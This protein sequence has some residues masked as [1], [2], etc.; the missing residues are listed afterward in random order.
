MSFL[1]ETNA[2]A[3][4][5]EGSLNTFNNNNNNNHQQQFDQTSN[6]QLDAQN[7]DK[8]PFPTTTQP[9]VSIRSPLQALIAMVIPTSLQQLSVWTPFALLRHR[10][11]PIDNNT[12]IKTA[13]D[14]AA[15]QNPSKHMHN[16][17]NPMA[18][19][20]SIAAERSK[21]SI[22]K[23]RRLQ[24]SIDS[25]YHGGS[26]CKKTRENFT[27][28]SEIP[29]VQRDNKTSLPLE[30][31]SERQRQRTPDIF[32]ALKEKPRYQG[33]KKSI[34]QAWQR[35]D[36]HVDPHKH[37][38]ILLR[39]KG[40]IAR[41]LKKKAV[42]KVHTQRKPLS[43]VD[44][45]GVK[46]IP[47]RLDKCNS[48]AY[49]K[50]M[51]ESVKTNYSE[52]E[53]EV[54]R[55]RQWKRICTRFALSGFDRH[56]SAIT[57]LWQL[58][59]AARQ[60][61]S[62]TNSSDIDDDSTTTND[63]SSLIDSDD[64]V[65]VSGSDSPTN[66]TTNEDDDSTTTNDL[67]FLIDSDDTVRVSGSDSPTNETTNE[68]DDSTT[69]NDL[70]SLIDS[71]DTV[72]VSGNDSPSNETTNEDDDC[73]TAND[74]SSRIDSDD[75]VRVSGS[76]SPTNETTNEDDDSTT[77]NDLSSRI[78]SDDTV[79]VSGSNFS[80]NETTNEDDD[81]MTK[82]DLSSRI[83]SDDTVRVSGSNF[84][85]NETT[86][87]DDDCMT[88]N[89]LSSRLDCDDT[90]RVSG[91]DSPSNETT[92]ED[93]D[94]TTTNDLSSRI[95][96]DDT[97]RVS[98]S[99]SLTNETTNE[100]DDCMTTNDLSSRL[101]CDDT[102]RVSGS[103]SPTNETTH[104]DDDSTTTNDLS[105]RIDSDDTVRVSGSN[106]STNETTNEDDDSTTTN[107]LSSSIDSDDTVR[108]SGSDS[109]TNETT[110]ED[111]DCMTTND[112]S[113]PIDSDD[114]VRVSGSNLSTN[115][116]T[117]E[118]DDSTTTNAATQNPS[119]HMH[120]W[121]NPM[122]GMDSIAAE[123]SKSSI[124][125]VRR[126]QDSIDSKYPGGS[127]CK[128][129]RENFTALSEIPAVQH[130]N[131]T[132]L[133]LEDCSERQRQRTP[134]IFVALKEKP[135]Y[136]GPKKSIW[137]AWE[138]DDPH[139]NPHKHG[140]ILLRDVGGIARILKWEAAM[141][142]EIPYRKPLSFVGQT[143]VKFIPR[144]LDKC[145]ANAYLK[146][147]KE[148]VKRN[149]SEVDEEVGRRRQWKR[150]CTR[151]ALAGFNRHYSAITS[152][153]QLRAAARQEASTTDSSDI[154]DDSTTTNDLSSRID[155]DDTVRVS[156]SNFSTNETTN[157]D[158]DS[159]TTNDL[160]S[161]IDSDDTVRVSGSDSPTNETTNEDNDST[162]TNDLSSRIDSDDTVRVSG[163]NFSA[164]E[165][166]NE[167]D[168]CMTTND[169]SSPIDSDDTVRVSGS[170]LSTNDTT[171]GE[172][173]TTRRH[174]RTFIKS[175]AMEVDG[176]TVWVN[177]RRRSS[178]LQPKTGSIWMNGQ[179][180][181]A[182][183]LS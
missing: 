119:K 68:D 176:A 38:C 63:L 44:Q 136:Q 132:S 161:R 94:S 175:T 115:E 58:R 21:S 97:V 75:T 27:A 122:A 16:W 167:D 147:L 125:K 10:S 61:A 182:R 183:F 56:Y 124:L 74:L 163:S 77:T 99:D 35:D 9:P 41:I 141:E 36:P 134:D 48:N 81:C 59:A 100:D 84:S 93:D 91:N 96:S 62:T 177:G 69:T 50:D 146:D 13:P 83:D 150:I 55:R 47:R 70:S 64:T 82:N 144:R 120:S 86:N 22:L 160:S 78:D 54:G 53:E 52:V 18:G 20:D 112:L 85:T 128:K 159:T 181:S 131:K 153:W 152:Q 1:G 114:T 109:L 101:D 98:G 145:N 39:D 107:D 5:A 8:E 156:C 45:V 23:V 95:D 26:D 121:T 73:M 19:M 42:V 148:S 67:S 157:E 113:S 49:I 29:A 117:N 123:R 142:D 180:R 143:G 14:N 110:N 179:R 72:R 15:T 37:G 46:F 137:Q 60:E 165:T 126:L 51:K 106:F 34:W 171:N 103:D 172:S 118:D 116:T 178:R 133:P 149:Y 12:S 154:D 139:V 169:L 108:V 127:D 164:N 105:S 174:R 111:D 138:R 43:F 87:E 28:L 17:T 102:V 88:T 31:C 129:T 11:R 57:S 130:D 4:H 6:R 173:T 155:R 40:G 66:E 140:C 2:T 166:T 7:Q 168:D 79:R 158:D 3:A 89:D 65:R 162:T 30:D 80:T 25:K 104:E 92:N 76:D 90:V 71:D 151:F 170:N 32:V 135:R 24:D 33:P